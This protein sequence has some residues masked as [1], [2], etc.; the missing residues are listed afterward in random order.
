MFTFYIPVL[1]ATGNRVRFSTPDEQILFPDKQS[2]TAP[3]TGFV[4][5]AAAFPNETACQ[6]DPPRACPLYPQAVMIEALSPSAP[7]PAPPSRPPSPP[8][9]PPRAPPRGPP[10]PSPPPP[11]PPPPSPPPS[12]SPSPPSASPS[13]PPTPPPTPPP[14]TSNFKSPHSKESVHRHGDSCSWAKRQNGAP[15]SRHGSTAH[16]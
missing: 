9:P 1:N 12:P 10:P 15:K 4:A 6:I 16:S 14:P 5:P 7:P 2:Y 8:P 3:Q 11:S 13:P